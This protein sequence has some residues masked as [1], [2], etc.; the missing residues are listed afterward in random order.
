MRWLTSGRTPC[1]CLFAFFLYK[2]HIPI[3]KFRES[4][5]FKGDTKRRRLLAYKRKKTKQN[6]TCV[7]RMVL[8]QY[9][10]IKS[11]VYFWEFR[12]PPG[13]VIIIGCRW[14]AEKDWLVMYMTLLPHIPTLFVTSQT[15]AVKASNGSCSHGRV[16]VTLKRRFLTHQTNDVSVF[17]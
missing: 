9:I 13:T 1:V 10:C 3:T 17:F 15:Q 16:L 5:Y 2:P 6:K 14:R 4:E 7:L 11:T 12:P 8:Y